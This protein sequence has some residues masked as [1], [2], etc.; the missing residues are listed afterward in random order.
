MKKLTQLKNLM[1]ARN[2]HIHAVHEK[3]RI[4]HAN[5]VE[6]RFP[7]MAIA[8]ATWRQTQNTNL[9]C[10]LTVE[11]ASNLE[12]VT[13]Y[14]SLTNI[15]QTLVVIIPTVVKNATNGSTVR[16]IWGKLTTT[17]TTTF[18]TT[19]TTT[20]TARMCN[21]LGNPLSEPIA[22]PARQRTGRNF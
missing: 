9:M 8:N 17:T 11:S 3:K 10:A 5:C 18:T 19:T 12:R 6:K 16:K 21:Y 22:I 14:M 1:C 20:T 7:R 2:E 4:S 15:W 13:K